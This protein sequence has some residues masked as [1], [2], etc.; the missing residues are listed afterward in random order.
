MKNKKFNIY[1]MITE[2]IIKALE[3]GTIPWRRTWQGKAPMNLISKKNY[4]GINFLLLSSFEFPSP[5]FA[6]FN[7][8]KGKGG[9]VNKGAK[10]IPIVYWKL[11]KYVDEETGEENTSSFIRYY[12]VFNISETSLYVPEK[13]KPATSSAVYDKAEEIIKAV[14]ENV[15]VRENSSRAFY[16]A[17]RDYI[18]LPPVNSFE[19]VEAYY[20]VFYH[21]TVHWTGSER[22]LKRF[23][24]FENKHH[25]YSFEEL[26]AEIGASYLCG[27][28]GIKDE[29]VIENSAAYIQEWLKKLK[30]DKMYIYRA[31]AQARKAVEFITTL[32]QKQKVSPAA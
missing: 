11:K 27:I 31:S 25:A 28:T 32:N 6:T 30:D 13:E 24:E 1:E 18:S 22:R 16:N 4:S 23:H 20:S 19:S 5:Y 12:Y 10:A 9:T 8:I 3:A 7:Q 2:R 29:R 15:E 14:K 21:E 26:V 17:T